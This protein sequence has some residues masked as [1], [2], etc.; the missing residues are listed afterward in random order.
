MPPQQQQPPPQLIE[1]FPTS[2][3]L[4]H[5]LLHHWVSKL[6]VEGFGRT[7]E[8]RLSRANEQDHPETLQKMMQTHQAYGNERW[9][10]L[11]DQDRHAMTE[12]GWTAA[13][14]TGVAG[15]HY[16]NR[17][18][19]QKKNSHSA[20]S[21]KCLHAHTAHRLAGHDN[22]IGQWV[23]DELIRRAQCATTV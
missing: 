1:P 2:Y 21:V 13:L 23:L 14:Q 7:L 10:L 9:W 3:W 22:L 4:T 5:P 17:T 18:K 15:N 12:R 19:K 16:S 20:L 8:E 11:T 6:E